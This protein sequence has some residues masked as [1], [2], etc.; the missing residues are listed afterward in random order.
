VSAGPARK[1]AGC[2]MQQLGR[3]VKRARPADSAG[4][5]RKQQ[6]QHCRRLEVDRG[7]VGRLIGRGGRN[8]NT[9]RR[10]T[11]E[12]PSPS[13]I[14]SRAVDLRCHDRTGATIDFGYADADPATQPGIAT[15]SGLSTGAG[16]ELVRITVS[17]GA[18]AVESAVG[19]IEACLAKAQVSAARL[20]RLYTHNTR[21][22]S[23]RCA[24]LELAAAA[25]FGPIAEY[26]ALRGRCGGV[27]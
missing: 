26:R 14:A 27:R 5:H 18:D 19:H 8:V 9:I 4:G 13:E 20:S 12:D 22:R 21:I 24:H 2:L 10:G 7:V 3:E 25:A 6:P 15:I 17:G 11:G 1:R 16:Q 23:V